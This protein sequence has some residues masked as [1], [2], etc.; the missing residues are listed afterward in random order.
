MTQ[1]IEP[2]DHNGYAILGTFE[3]NGPG[4]QEPHRLPGRADDA[5]AGHAKTMGKPFELDRAQD[6]EIS[7]LRLMVKELM[8]QLIRTGAVTEEALQARVSDRLLAEQEKT[9]APSTLR[10]LWRAGAAERD[11]LFLPRRGLCRRPL[12]LNNSETHRCV[13]VRRAPLG[14]CGNLRVTRLA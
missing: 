5:D 2:R 3:R 9:S 4:V 11:L 7:N 14:S 10:L 12:R 6:R 8:G 1:T 13:L